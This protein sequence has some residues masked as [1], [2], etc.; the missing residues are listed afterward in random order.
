MNWRILLY[1][2]QTLSPGLLWG[3]AWPQ[4]CLQVTY[5]SE[6]ITACWVHQHTSSENIPHGSTVK[7]AGYNPNPLN[8]LTSREI[9]LFLETQIAALLSGY[10]LLHSWRVVYTLWKHFVGSVLTDPLDKC[11]SVLAVGVLAGRSLRSTSSSHI[12]CLK[13]K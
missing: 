9:Y 5:L 12:F 6:H 7:A 13:H 3:I 10:K 11:V 2:W 8:I 1:L 4:P